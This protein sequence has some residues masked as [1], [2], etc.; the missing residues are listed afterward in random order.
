M[1]RPC[2]YSDKPSKHQLKTARGILRWKFG[3][4]RLSSYDVLQFR[5]E[6]DDQESARTKRLAN[7]F[8]SFKQLFF[9]LAQKWT[10]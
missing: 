6:I 7:G 10:D 8:A 3:D 9:A 4:W 5:D 2:K 1:F